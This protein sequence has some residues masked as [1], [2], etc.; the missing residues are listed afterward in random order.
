MAPWT[1]WSARIDELALRERALAFVGVAAALVIVAH[2]IALRPLLAQQRAYLD[3]IKQDQ[4]QLKS[5]NDVLLKSAQASVEDPHAA[6]RDRIREL[7]ARLAESGRKLGERRK[8][9]LTPDQL[10]RLLQDIV[11]RNRNLRVHAL[12]VLPGTVLSASAPGQAPGAAPKAAPKPAAPLYRHQVEI[13]MA[14]SYLDLLKYLEDVE[15][16]PWR[17]TWTN[18]ALRTASYPE[19]R[20]KGTLQTV[21]ASPTLITF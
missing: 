3:R 8:G 16:L 5:I 18:V 9:E 21:S 14:G 7:E 17:L 20:L 13:E 6:K 10:T 15:A 19:I 4:G 2:L 11:G 1:R 12:R